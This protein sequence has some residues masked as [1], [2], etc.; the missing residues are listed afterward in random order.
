MPPT[1]TTNSTSNTSQIL[2]SRLLYLQTF[3]IIPVNHNSVRTAP[4]FFV[5]LLSLFLNRPNLHFCLFS[6][7]RRSLVAIDEAE[8]MI[9]RMSPSTL[10]ISDS[11]VSHIKK[12]EKLGAGDRD[13][14]VIGDY[15]YEI[16]PKE[17][18]D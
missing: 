12:V 4:N 17:W 16:W 8:L 14:K 11:V 2:R 10:S 15:D 6:P 18:K 7:R 9:S 3:L 13:H 5:A 1:Q